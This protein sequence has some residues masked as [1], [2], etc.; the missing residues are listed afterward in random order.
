MIIRVTEEEAWKRHL[1][2]IRA[3]YSKSSSTFKFEMRIKIDLMILAIRILISILV[4]IA[5]EC[6]KEKLVAYKKEED[7]V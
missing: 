7:E 4:K 5:P 6:R 2:S 3:K 1:D